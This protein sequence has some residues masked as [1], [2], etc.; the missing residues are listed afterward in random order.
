[1]EFEVDVE[2]FLSDLPNQIKQAR[3]QLFSRNFNPLEF[4]FI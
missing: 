3:R 4:G 2:Q 1:M